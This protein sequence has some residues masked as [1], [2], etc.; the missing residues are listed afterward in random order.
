MREQLARRDD[1]RLYQPRVHAPWIRELHRIGQETGLRM[2][3]LV[4]QAVREY[5]LAHELLKQG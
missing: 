5:C 2:S 4:N 3:V 1:E